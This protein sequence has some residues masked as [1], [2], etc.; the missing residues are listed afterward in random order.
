MMALAYINPEGAGL[1]KYVKSLGN[2][3]NLIVNQFVERYRKTYIKT[4]I[5]SRRRRKL[6]ILTLLLL[7]FG[8]LFGVLIINILLPLLGQ[9]IAV[10]E[11]PLVVTIYFMLL[12]VSPIMRITYLYSSNMKINVIAQL[13][14]V[15]VIVLLFY[16]GQEEST[17]Y[18]ILPVMVGFTIFVTNIITLK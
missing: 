4:L 16:F 11:L 8:L 3:Q 12:A 9:F 17:G 13:L 14:I 1:I 18:L 2:G 10:P 7:C 6:L 15:L 5:E